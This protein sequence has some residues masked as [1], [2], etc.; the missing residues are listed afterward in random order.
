MDGVKNDS[1]W[2]PQ[3]PSG[4]LHGTLSLFGLDTSY[5]PALIH[6]PVELAVL[7]PALKV[8]MFRQIGE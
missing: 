3:R 2:P 5:T 4:L 1:G 7:L 6:S 8:V